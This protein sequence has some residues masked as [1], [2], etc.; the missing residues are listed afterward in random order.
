MSADRK[1]IGKKL[2]FEVFKRD[3]F[4]CQYCG[5]KAP[6][7]VLQVDHLQP[8]ALGGA[9]EILNLI[10]SCVDC[11]SGKGARTLSDDSALAKQRA[12]LEAL[13]E[14]REQLDMML[15]WSAELG[16]LLDY[17]VD[18]VA[19]RI[20]L[21]IPAFS[22][23]LDGRN[24]IRQWLQKYSLLELME[25]L[26]VGVSQYIR[27]DSGM[28]DRERCFNSIPGIARMRRL[29]QDERDLYYVRGIARKRFSRCDDEVAID[30]LRRAAAA[31]HDSE[32]LKATARREGSWSSWV[33]AM[34]D[35]IG[36]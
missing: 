9:N 19:E 23:G 12:Q 29:P 11:N 15:E 24:K 30:L 1:A 21:H 17:E 7:V 36:D 22:V 3:K 8:V 27:G 33:N 5:H 28:D 14:R 16:E 20:E 2:R 10:T 31:G 35:L 6:D 34:Y 13:A 26:S 32:T 25:A 18:S 4:T